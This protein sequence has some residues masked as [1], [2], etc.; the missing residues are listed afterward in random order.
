MGV[1]KGITD[2][3]FRCPVNYGLGVDKLIKKGKYDLVN[4]RWVHNEITENN[5]PTKRGGQKEV[6]MKIFHFR[7]KRTLEEYSK[8]KDREGFL[9][10]YLF[11]GEFWEKDVTLK[12][13]KAEMANQGY[14]PAKLCELLAFEDAYPEYL[15][16]TG[17]LIALGSACRNSDGCRQFP[18]LSESVFERKKWLHL[19]LV[20]K[21][22]DGL[23]WTCYFLA[24]RK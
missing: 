16:S 19:S 5:F 6:E 23:G 12:E 11:K 8:A 22:K 7:K 14:R 1:I 21:G 10:Q 17:L 4:N 9:S 2:I 15:W 20:K 24:V 3:V 13:V 18:Y